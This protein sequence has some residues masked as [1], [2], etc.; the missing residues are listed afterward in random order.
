MLKVEMDLS[1]EDTQK[2][3]FRPLLAIAK[4]MKDAADKKEK[5]SLLTIVFR[6]VKNY[7]IIEE[8][9]KQITNGTN[10]GTGNKD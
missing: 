8:Q 9:Q 2:E 1:N 5:V 4:S 10:P 7:K 6:S 3:W